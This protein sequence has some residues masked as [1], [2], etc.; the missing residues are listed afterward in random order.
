MK[1][2]YN[3]AISIHQLFPR[4]INKILHFLYWPETCSHFREPI[5][6]WAYPVFYLR[7][8]SQMLSPY[9]FHTESENPATAIPALLA[10]L[11]SCCNPWIYMFFSGHLL[12][13]CAQSFPCCQNMK[14]TFAREDSDSMSRRQTSFTNNRSPTNSVGTWKDSPKSSKSIKFIPV[15]TWAPCVHAVWPLQWTFQ[16][17]DWIQ[18]ELLDKWTYIKLINLLSTRVCFSLHFSHCY[19]Q[20]LWNVL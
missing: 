14:R 17:I 3:Q 8:I 2:F 7:L 6:G 18:L 13:D 4:L 19:K 12:Q 10:S 15:S 11:N 20:K 1:I 5:K 16:P 9:V